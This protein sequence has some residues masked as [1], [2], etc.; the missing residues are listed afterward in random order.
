MYCISSGIH[1]TNQV[2]YVSK[3]NLDKMRIRKI[4]MAEP[5]IYPSV[6]LLNR[7]LWFEKNYFQFH[8][9]KGIIISG[10]KSAYP[11]SDTILKVNWL[12]IS[13]NKWLDPDTFLKTIKP[14]LVIVS[15][16]VPSY[17]LE[18]YSR[19]LKIKKQPFYIVNTK[20]AYVS[21]L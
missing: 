12:I 4:L 17:L 19:E 2:D 21:K 8:S 6:P 14:E 3:G 13:G 1:G 18:R 5:D 11:L 15:S 9:K 10:R 20:G 7:S 16:A